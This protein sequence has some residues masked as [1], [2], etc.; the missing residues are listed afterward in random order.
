[1]SIMHFKMLGLLALKLIEV[2]PNLFAPLSLPPRLER[3]MD[4]VS[5]SSSI[6]VKTNIGGFFPIGITPQ[7]FIPSFSVPRSVLGVPWPTVVIL[8]VKTLSCKSRMSGGG[9]KDCLSAALNSLKLLPS[10]SL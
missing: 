4:L 8:V 1:M 5:G 10:D 3:E 2:D 7:R 9:R 6:P